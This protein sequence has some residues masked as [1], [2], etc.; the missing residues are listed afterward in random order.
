METADLKLGQK[1]IFRSIDDETTSVTGHLVNLD[2]K[3]LTLSTSLGPL[4]FLRDK[5][6]I[7]TVSA[8]P[9]QKHEN[10]SK[11]PERAANER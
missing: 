2:D 1:I 7:E 9:A 4:T 10:T 11:H 5:G 6:K 8:E 3:S